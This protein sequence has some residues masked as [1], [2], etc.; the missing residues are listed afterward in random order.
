MRSRNVIIAI[1]VI[2]LIAL[3]V[4]AF[5]S[6]LRTPPEE[7]PPA[8]SPPT[9]PAPTPPTSGTPSDD[10]PVRSIEWDERSVV[11][12]TG[13]TLVVVDD[14]QTDV[15]VSEEASFGSDGFFSDVVLSPDG[16][17]LALTISGAAHG[18][19]WLYDLPA[20]ERD[21]VAFQYGGSLEVVEWSPDDRFVVFRAH[22]PAETTHL[23]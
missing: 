5:V 6:A 14:F 3:A 9:V 11:D 13:D 23:K 12:L 8:E 1:I 16:R 22:S 18:F 17:Y 2:L 20:E 10:V 4:W 19:G 15:P 7:V 21:P